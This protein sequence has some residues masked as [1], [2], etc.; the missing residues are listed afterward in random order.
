MS[1]DCYCGAMR[2]IDDCCGPYLAGEA[3][4]PTP[5]ALM[6]S[7]YSAYVTGNNAYLLSTWHPDT[8]PA[9]L[10]V[11]AEAGA[12]FGL[13]VL[14]AS[15]KGDTGIVEFEAFYRQD[16]RMYTM[17]ER[18]RFVRENGQWLYVDGDQLEQK[19]IKPVKVGRNDPCPCGSGK[20]FKRCCMK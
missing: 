20:K 15:E 18:S 11:S 2:N 6:R 8:R 12:W 1:E 13:N 14:N 5:E 4:A 10:D 3:Q 7:R 9:E 16:E 17:H 19:P